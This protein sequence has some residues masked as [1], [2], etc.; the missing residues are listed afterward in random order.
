MKRILLIVFICFFG[1]NTIIAQDNSQCEVSVMATKNV[2]LR[3]K[4]V[5]KIN[6]AKNHPMVSSITKKRGIPVCSLSIKNEYT[7]NINVFVDSAY[8]GFIEPYQTGV[9]ECPKGYS[10]VHAFAQHGEYKWVEH[11]SCKECTKTFVIL[12]E[13]G[14]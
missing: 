13:E 11:G 10:I 1:I 12:P 5:F 3:G 2:K 8:V 6:E 7:T 14:K 4:E 9:M